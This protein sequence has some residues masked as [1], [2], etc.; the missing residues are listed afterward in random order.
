MQHD[1]A[2]HDGI[3]W[4]APLALLA[5]LGGCALDA[6]DGEALEA[7]EEAVARE[8]A[9]A[10]AGTLSST[11]DGPHAHWRVTSS[12][13]DR[14][15]LIDRLTQLDADDIDI[16]AMVTDPG[17]QWLIVDEN[18]QVYRSTGFPSGPRLAVG[19]LLSAG[20]QVR[21]M[22]FNPGGGWVVIGD[23][24][25]L[26]GGLVPQS[27]LDAIEWYL[28]TQGWLIRDV[29]I[30]AGGYVILGPGTAVSYSGIDS[31]LAAVLADRAAGQR[32]VQQVEIGFDGHWAVV[33][34]QAPA[35]EG[36]STTLAESLKD[37]A[38]EGWRVS[39]MMLG[40]GTSFVIYSHGQVAHA[41]GNPMEVI[42]Y[43]L[44]SAT[45]VT[46]LWKRMEEAGVT[47]ASIAI[48]DGNQV[49][50]ARS[51]GALK[52]GEQ[53]PVLSTTPF[54]L[55]SLSKYVGALMVLRVRHL[56]WLASID[57]DILAQPWATI[58][59]WETIGSLQPSALNSYGIPAVSLPAGMTVRN[60][61]RHRAGIR[62]EGGSPGVLAQYWSSLGSVDTLDWL[63]S[64]GCAGTVCNFKE[65]RYVWT[66]PSLAPGQFDYASSNYLLAQAIAEDA[67]GG[68]AGADL[69]QG[70]FFG[71]MGLQDISGR[72]PLA[73]AFE[74]RAAWQHGDAGPA[75]QRSVYPWTFAGGVYASAVDYAEML[76]LALNG[77]RDSNGVQRISAGLIDVMLNGQDS[78][79][80]FGMFFETGFTAAEGTDGAF[81][82]NGSHGGRAHT[83]MCGNPT[84]D[85]GIVVL[86]NAQTV[87]SSDSSGALMNDVVSTYARAMGWPGTL[88]CR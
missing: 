43:D 22:D 80:G 45:G 41:P 8:T 70:H 16:D 78:S 13:Q 68:T 10:R 57:Q 81:N 39:R 35:T 36:V 17:G 4:L 33:S 24:D 29:D 21:A 74:A 83:R 53:R 44:D 26:S 61:L 51:Y 5:A 82:H 3:R 71:P 12:Y 49:V 32:T 11:T 55:A 37:A 25:Y 58:S 23:S 15:A 67:A 38:E 14:T 18:D 73:A 7:L 20:Q 47:G 6:E 75:S 88:N 87:T 66:D 85:Q 86:L 77:G 63:L 40:V 62:A 31:D 84:R 48:V 28:D 79:A 69:L 65:G 27:A 42:E 46:N 34:S 9:A 76:I 52:Q 56:G 64:W 60:L 2:R 1:P 72:A 54:D 50:S 19:L 30:T 59:G